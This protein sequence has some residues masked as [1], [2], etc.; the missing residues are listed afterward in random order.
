MFF[1]PPLHIQTAQRSP[2]GAARLCK[3]RTPSVLVR[4][5]QRGAQPQCPRA[6]FVNPEKVLSA[7]QLTEWEEA[8]GVLTSL[9]DSLLPP[10]K[11]DA[12]LLRAFGWRSQRFWRGRK[13]NEAPS[14]TAVRD[15]LAFLREGVGV[16]G[17]RE[18]AELL[19]KFPELLGV[20]V[21]RMR[22]NVSTIERTY[23]SLKGA[24]LTRAVISNPAVLGYDFDCEGDCK[25]ECAR[26]WVQF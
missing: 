10:D 13:S 19:V 11:A 1:I 15:A 7:E 18:T 8:A 22:D 4:S 2:L 6:A 24:G 21:T 14:V 12:L 23:P 16:E 9:D 17:D 25:S 3:H 5:A 20:G 26:C